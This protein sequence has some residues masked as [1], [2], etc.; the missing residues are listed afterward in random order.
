MIRA[1]ENHL[2]LYAF[3][4][5]NL[6]F[7][8]LG[9]RRCQLCWWDS[10][11]LYIFCQKSLSRANSSSWV[12]RVNLA[13]SSQW[14]SISHYS[15][16]I[17]LHIFFPCFSLIISGN[18]SVMAPSADS[19]PHPLQNWTLQISVPHQGQYCIS[20]VYSSNLSWWINKTL[21]LFGQYKVFGVTI[22]QYPIW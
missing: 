10:E 13:T 20:H 15:H 22:D 18:D 4:V 6:M 11:G 7:L 21:A 5:L 2:L 17:N 19:H 9:I 16:P 8:F 1:T 3:D 14:K 12:F